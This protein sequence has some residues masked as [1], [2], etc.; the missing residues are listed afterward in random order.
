M[1]HSLAHSSAPSGT[2]QRI[3]LRLKTAG[4]QATAELATWLGISGEGARQQLARLRRDGLVQ[5]RA[6]R[7]GVGRPTLGWTLT[8]LGH[9]RFPDGHA[10]LAVGL[11]HSVRAALG[12]AAVVTLVDAR[13][14]EIRRRYRA[15]LS[16]CTSLESRVAAL[17][18]LRTEDG[19]LCDYRV[20]GDGSFLLVEHH[21]PI[22]S[23][24][25]ACQAF[26]DSELATFADLLA[27]AQVS[28][29]EHLQAGDARCAYRIT[30]V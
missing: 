6:V 2:A 8:D 27:P 1:R 23:A 3:L 24:A 5:S 25:Q 30:P 19:Y 9:Q 16:A 17:A 12:E 29:L 20:E 10:G 22:C 28:R 7:A 15:C 14:R 21:C 4:E 26:C 11:L 13:D 18:G